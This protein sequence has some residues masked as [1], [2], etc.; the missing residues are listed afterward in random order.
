MRS[1]KS[2]INEIFKGLEFTEDEIEIIASVF[3]KVTYKKGDILLK[4][5]ETTD[6]QYYTYE[7]CLR[8]YHTDLSGKEY[9]VQFA[10]K[11]WWMSDYTAFFSDSK[12]IMNIEVIQDVILYRICKKDKETLYAKIPRIE[13]FFRKKLERAFAAFQKRILS[14]ISQTATERYINF[15]N[16]YPE[17][18]KEVKN[19]HIASYLGITTESLS[20]IRKEI[21]SN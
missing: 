21:A 20:R 17:I 13:S 3:H 18:E 8:S 15:R 14:N 1:D 9:T 7:G 6:Y 12:S 5:G 11:D 10:I 19:Y 16:S 4:T 2:K